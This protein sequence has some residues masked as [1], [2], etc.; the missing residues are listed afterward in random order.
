MSS[1][2]ERRIGLRAP[3]ATTTQAP[4]TSTVNPTASG[5]PTPDDQTPTTQS[6]TPQSQAAAEGE[7]GEAPP[8]EMVR[9]DIPM[10]PREYRTVREPDGREF[11]FRI[12]STA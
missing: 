5:Q 4:T 12:V 2:S 11:A 1:P 7:A 9:K 3:S 8:Y 10:R 6:G